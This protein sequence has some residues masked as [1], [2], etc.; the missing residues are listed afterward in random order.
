MDL[1]FSPPLIE[2]RLHALSSHDILPAFLVLPPSLLGDR[3]HMRQHLPGYTHD[4]ILVRNDPIT[5]VHLDVER[6]KARARAGT[7]SR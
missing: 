3:A 2:A 1:Q 4:P 5:R 6:A 7:T